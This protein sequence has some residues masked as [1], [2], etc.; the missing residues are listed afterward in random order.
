MSEN[1]T[2]PGVVEVR[3]SGAPDD[4]ERVIALMGSWVLMRRGPY[5]NRH[6]PGERVYLTLQLP[7][8]TS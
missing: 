6:D 5:L 1:R 7:G 2:A 3:V 8:G 4:I